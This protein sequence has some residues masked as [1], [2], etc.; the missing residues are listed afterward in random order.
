MTRI[1]TLITLMILGT[2]AVKTQDDPSP[3]KTHGMLN[4][5]AWRSYSFREKL[6][7]VG[8]ASDGFIDGIYRVLPRESECRRTVEAAIPDWIRSNV[9][10]AGIIK[11]MDSFYEDGANI[12]LPTSDAFEY[13]EMKLSGATKKELDDYLNAIRQVAAK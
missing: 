13:S 3:F 6:L 12:S 1:L 9:T 4:G 11:E 2:L 8:G 7:Y 10:G 5:V